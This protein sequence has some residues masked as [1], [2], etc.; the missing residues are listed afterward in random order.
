MTVPLVVTVVFTAVTLPARAFL[1]GGGLRHSQQTF[2]VE[3]ACSTA[4]TTFKI[5]THP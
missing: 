3:H 4:C 5:W 2:C 1:A